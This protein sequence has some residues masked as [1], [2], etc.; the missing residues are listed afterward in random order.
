M[1]VLVDAAM[2]FQIIR[3]LARQLLHKSTE[4][5]PGTQAPHQWAA[6]QNP[7]NHAV[8]LLV[9]QK[10]HRYSLENGHIDPHAHNQLAEHMPS[11]DEPP[12]HDHMHTHLQH[13]PPVPDPGEPPTWVPDVVIYKYTRRAYH[14]PQPLRTTAHILGSHANNT[15]MTRLQH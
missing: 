3:Q 11:P 1:W 4:S 5:S 9:K 6:L 12:L 15:L 8:L 10:S 14:Y 2:D 7:P 13:L